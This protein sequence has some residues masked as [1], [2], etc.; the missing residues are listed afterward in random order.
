MKMVRESF[1]TNGAAIYP[2]V[3]EAKKTLA[4]ILLLIKR[5]NIY[6]RSLTQP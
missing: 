1:V 2:V 5:G 4:R 6:P 3:W